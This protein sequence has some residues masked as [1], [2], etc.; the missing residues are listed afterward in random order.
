LPNQKATGNV[1]LISGTDVQ[2]TEA[3]GDLVTNEVWVQRLREKMGVGPGQPMPFFE[4]LLEGKQ[5]NYTV[6][7][8]EIVAW[9]KH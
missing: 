3:G 9:R 8:F 6:P 1:L 7:R 2:S 5:Y 4:A